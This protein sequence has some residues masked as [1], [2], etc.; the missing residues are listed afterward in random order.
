M[1]SGFD[2]K[3]FLRDWREQKDQ[4]AVDLKLSEPQ[5]VLLGG[6]AL[7]NPSKDLFKVWVT[8]VLVVTMLMITAVGVLFWATG[9]LPVPCGDP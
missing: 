6:D 2:P 7:G 8:M 9:V 4:T 1:S 5:Q 3:R